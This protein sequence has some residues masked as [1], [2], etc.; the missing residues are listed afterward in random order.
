MKK[1]FKFIGAV[2]AVFTGIIAA[3]AVLGRLF[4]RKGS[5]GYLDISDNA[6]E[7]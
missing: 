5:N 7:Q 4:R 1:F 3:F 6:S 2:A